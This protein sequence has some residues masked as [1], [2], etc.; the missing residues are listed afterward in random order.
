MENTQGRL[1]MTDPNAQHQCAEMPAQGV[2]VHRA[3]EFLD[4]P[5]RWC[6][7]VFREAT[8]LDLEENHYLEE[9][10]E[11][12]WQTIVGISHCPYCGERLA[13]GSES[14][15]PPDTASDMES[16]FYH[17]DSTGWQSKYQ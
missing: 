1:T 6:L 8:E 13:S 2:G 17:I 12:L 9:V 10:G 5:W 7:V 14:Q 4:G 3:D 11:T 16:A 15:I